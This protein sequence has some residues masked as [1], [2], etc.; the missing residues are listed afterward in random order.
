MAPPRPPLSL[1]GPLLTLSL[2]LSACGGTPFGDALS[3]SFS[4]APQAPTAPPPAARTT[5]PAPPAPVRPAPAP[6]AEIGRAHV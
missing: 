1:A 2:L 6:A 5:A 4:G 3:R